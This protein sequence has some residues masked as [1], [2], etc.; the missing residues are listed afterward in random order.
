M[1]YHGLLL[2]LLCNIPCTDK[3]KINCGIQDD[4]GSRY[5]FLLIYSLSRILKVTAL[6]LNSRSTCEFRHFHSSDAQMVLVVN[7]PAFF[8]HGL[9]GSGS[10]W[11]NCFDIFLDRALLRYVV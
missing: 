11:G 4:T 6:L 2:V 5:F 10:G 1:P 8:W 3:S 9:F 7:Q